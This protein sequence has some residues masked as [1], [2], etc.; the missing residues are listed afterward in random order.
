MNLMDIDLPLI[1]YLWLIINIFV[2]SFLI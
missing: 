1:S 2:L